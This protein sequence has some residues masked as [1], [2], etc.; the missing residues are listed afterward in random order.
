[1]KN[2]FKVLGII[3]FVAVI[4]FSMVSCAEEEES[5]G[6]GITCKYYI[7][8]IFGWGS[9]SNASNSYVIISFE[10]ENMYND[11]DK[12]R[13]TTIL[14]AIE[15]LTI[16]DFIFTPSDIMEKTSIYYVSGET[17]TMINV[18]KLKNYD[19]PPEITINSKN[20]VSFI[21]R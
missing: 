11:S 2:V 3:A 5:D 21:K 12:K 19:N 4:G 13:N 1:M 10:L 15:A 17:Q 20:G 14:E 8:H 7:D 18:K 16:D 6:G 9:M